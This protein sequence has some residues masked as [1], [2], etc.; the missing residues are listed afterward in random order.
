AP[1]GASSRRRSPAVGRR[2]GTSIASADRA[3][4]D[5]EL[6]AEDEPQPASAVASAA[7]EAPLHRRAGAMAPR[8]LT[9]GPSGTP[10]ASARSPPPCRA[11]RA[12]AAAGPT[13][14]SAG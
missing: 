3:E 12:G 5:V 1:A 2:S 9:A 13:R 14:P 4:G 7:T 6:D 8:P 11:R 10:P